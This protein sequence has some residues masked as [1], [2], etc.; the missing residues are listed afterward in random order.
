[1]VLSN[2][3]Q[4]KSLPLYNRLRNTKCYYQIR[5]QQVV[6]HSVEVVAKHGQQYLLQNCNY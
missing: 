6:M 3:Q 4:W 1:M 5:N 2:M